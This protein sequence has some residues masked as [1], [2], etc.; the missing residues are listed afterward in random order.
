MGNKF[1]PKA[2]PLTEY[3]DERE[4]ICIGMWGEKE[5]F[6]SLKGFVSVIADALD[7]EFEYDRESK[8]FLHPGRSAKVV[9]NGETVGYLGQVIYE[10]CDEMDM[11]VPAYIAEIDLKAL[12]KYYGKDR[13]FIPLPKFLEEKRDFCFVMDKFSSV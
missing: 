5:D 8:T 4:T 9:C 13:K 6:F 7:V 11:R 3:P 1:I 2:L 10:I 12:S